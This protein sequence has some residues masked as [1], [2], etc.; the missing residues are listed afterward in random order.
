MKLVVEPLDTDP[1]PGV[2]S[3]TVSSGAVTVRVALFEVTP[4]VVAVIVLLPCVREA[5][6]PLVFSVATEVL[7]DVQVTLPDA[8]PLVPSV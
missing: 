2:M 8:L 1:V 4:L 5:A 3:I 6:I 7:L